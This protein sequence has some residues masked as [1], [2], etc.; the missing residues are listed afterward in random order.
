MVDSIALTIPEAMQ[1][2]NMDK[3]LGVREGDFTLLCALH[4]VSL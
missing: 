2:A 1:V 3:C 4:P